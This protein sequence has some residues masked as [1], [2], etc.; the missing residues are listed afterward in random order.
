MCRAQ[1]ELEVIRQ[2]ESGIKQGEP[3]DILS[4]RVGFPTHKYRYRRYLLGALLAKVELNCF[5]PKL[6][7]NRLPAPP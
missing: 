7:R 5:T 6:E 2:G 1:A 4:K 3:C